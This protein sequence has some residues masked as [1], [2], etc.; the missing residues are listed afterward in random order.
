MTLIILHANSINFN[1]KYSCPNQFIQNQI[2]SLLREFCAK[3]VDE[4][5]ALKIINS[6]THQIIYSTIS[7]NE[8]RDRLKMEDENVVDILKWLF[9]DETQI[10][11]SAVLTLH[12]KDE[13]P[14]R[15]NVSVF[16]S[17]SF[18]RFSKARLKGNLLGMRPVDAV[19]EPM[20]VVC[21]NIR[22]ERSVD[23]QCAFIIR[24]GDSEMQ[25]ATESEEELFKWMI[26]VSRFLKAL[27]LITIS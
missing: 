18:T 25:L 15:W 24:Y 16:I 2:K 19:M 12:P 6:F 9:K 20:L 21:E 1:L 13:E 5:A 17:I 26:K 23:D 7:S 27:K 10:D 11:L 3:C 22:V 14:T 8:S 4:G